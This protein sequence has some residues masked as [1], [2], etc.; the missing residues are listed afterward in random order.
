MEAKG[1]YLTEWGFAAAGTC[2]CITAWHLCQP[3]PQIQLDV[4]IDIGVS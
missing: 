2:S 3:G 4:I 1:Y